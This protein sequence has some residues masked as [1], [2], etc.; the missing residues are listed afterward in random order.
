MAQPPFDLDVALVDAAGSLTID[1][2]L[3]AEPD[4]EEPP[5][6]ETYSGSAEVVTL[7]AAA[8]GEQMFSRGMQGRPIPARLDV[9]E[10]RWDPALPGLRY[11]L[12]AESLP[13][14][15]FLVL[16]ALLT[17]THQAFEPL[18]RLVLRAREPAAADLDTRALLAR[19]PDVPARIHP[20]P[21]A[22]QEPDP[23]VRRNVEIRL[24]FQEPLSRDQYER[25]Q[26][27]LNIWD[28]LLLLGGFRLDFEEAEGLGTLGHISHESPRV[29]RHDLDRFEDSLSAFSAVFNLGAHLHAEG[30]PLEAIT[31]E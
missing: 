19:G 28:H 26:E 2:E 22:I 4:P 18:R 1:L 27:A 6:E 5:D 12:R 8:V 7:F 29:V 24:E 9:L 20:L 30:L 16:V 21:F 13:P 10:Q 14:E 15:S 31:I 23:D 17:Q 3:H 25:V 11:R